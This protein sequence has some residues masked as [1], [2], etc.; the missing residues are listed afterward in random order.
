[1]NSRWHLQHGVAEDRLLLVVS[2]Q[3]SDFVVIVTVVK[4]SSL[5]G[6]VFYREKAGCYP[7]RL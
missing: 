1:M 6:L 3:V 7:A 4:I 2:L 5:S